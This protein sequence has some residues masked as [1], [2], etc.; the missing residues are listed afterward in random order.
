MIISQKNISSAMS[1]INTLFIS[2]W[3]AQSLMYQPQSDLNYLMYILF[4]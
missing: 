3:L 4:I 2:V 1:A